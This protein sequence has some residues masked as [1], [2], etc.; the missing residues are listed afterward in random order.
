MIALLSNRFLRDKLVSV[1]D[2]FLPHP[3]GLCPQLFAFDFLLF[4]PFV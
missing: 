1:I 4:S 2:A 3:E